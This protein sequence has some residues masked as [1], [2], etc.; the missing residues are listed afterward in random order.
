[1]ESDPSWGAPTAG[2][3]PPLADLSALAR[4]LSR[5]SGR[6]ELT[7]LVAD[8]LRGL[9]PAARPVSVRL[10]LGRPFPDGDPRTLELSAATLWRVAA[11][12]VG[13]SEGG[14]RRDV[15]GAVERLLADPARNPK[16]P[17]LSLEDLVRAFDSLAAQRGR[18][19]RRA[20]EAILASLLERAAPA[21][22]GFLTRCILGEMGHGVSEGLLLEAIAQAAQ[23]PLEAV[24]RAAQLLG[25]IGEVAHQAFAP[26]PD[27]LTALVP[28][29]F[30]P[31]R[32][33]LAQAAQT[34]EAA[35]ADSP[36]GA[37][38]LE[39]KLD[40]MR[41]QIHVERDVVRL[42][43]RRLQDVTD[44]LPEVAAEVRGSLAAR[45][46][47]LDG[48]VVAVDAD[49]RPRP[50]Q[51]LLRRSRH[52]HGV[53]EARRAAPLRLVVFDLLL[54]GEESLV[55]RPYA[56]RWERLREV[57]GGLTPAPR[58]IPRSLAEARGFWREALEAGHEGLVVKRLD[59]PYSPGVRGGGWLKLKRAESLDLAILAAEYGVG[60]RAEWL[61]SYLLAARDEETG[62]LRPV[63]KIS[64]GLADETLR[65]MTARLQGLRIQQEGDTLWVEPRVVVEVQ[66][67]DLQP[68][69]LYPDG[70]ALRS[71]RLAR[72]REDKTPAE[73]DT[74]QHLRR[75]QAA[76]GV[77]RPPDQEEP[78]ASES[79]WP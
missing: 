32:P 5:T 65:S 6:V 9:P 28:R 16:A 21:E 39:F 61:S 14:S 3:P 62:E 58:C 34:L 38:A 76:Q 60:R 46:A 22:A 79:S 55:D 20:R 53:E 29:L 24:R 8:H 49:G 70:L 43:T 4:A 50:L 71:P 73:A 7:R 54:E 42:F 35:W 77:R 67:A 47:I 45:R 12:M 31:L 18:G 27:R 51:E 40:G 33:M 59:S 75:L 69:N 23:R 68:S 56:E 63:G 26:G 78:G 64:K 10:L 44:S 48:E 36:P 11:G 19:A 25:D 52:P 74:L 72:L 41:L 37:L 13:R 15:G 30:R 66:Y 1:M 57:N 2:A 17:P